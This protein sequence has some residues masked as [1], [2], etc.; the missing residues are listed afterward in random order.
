M[1]LGDTEFSPSF[2]IIGIDG[3]LEVY[4]GY[5]STFPGFFVELGYEQKLE[6]ADIMIQ[7]W[8]EY[9]KKVEVENENT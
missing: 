4:E 3:E 6:L 1:K 8:K 9:K 7:R 2:D 5:D